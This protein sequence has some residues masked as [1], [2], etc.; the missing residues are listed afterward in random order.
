MI[1]LAVNK[2]LTITKVTDNKKFTVKDDESDR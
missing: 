2:W 1:K